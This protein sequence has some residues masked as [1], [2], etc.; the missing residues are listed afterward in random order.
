M[1]EAAEKCFTSRNYSSVELVDLLATRPS[2]VPFSKRVQSL[3][4]RKD[5]EHKAIAASSLTSRN[6]SL[7]LTVDEEKELATEVLLL[8][9]RFTEL[10]WQSTLFSQAALTVIQ[11]IYLFRNRRIFFD[12]AGSMYEDERKEALHLFTSRRENTSLPL[13]K[14]FQHLI[15]ARVWNR[16]TSGIDKKEVFSDEFEDLEKV[17][18]RLNTV[19]N[20]YMLL[21]TGLVKKITSQLNTIYGES[22]T[23]QDAQQVGCFGVARAAYR[24]HQSSGVRFSTYAAHWIK[25]EIQRQSLAGRLI[26]ISSNTVEQYATASKAKD[27]KMLMRYGEIISNSTCVGHSTEDTTRIV[28]LSYFSQQNDPGPERSTE[29]KE[30]KKLVNHLV[31]THLSKKEADVIQ[32]RFALFPYHG[33]PQSIVDIA[34]QYG[35]TRSSVYQ[36][37]D[38]A[39][40]RLQKAFRNAHNVSPRC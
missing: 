8:R 20:I 18:Q 35:V 38:K 22:L 15:I 3:Q 13:A 30:L 24:Y 27:K 12:P 2:Q 10:V 11:N 7:Q 4:L 31:Q 26:R 17:V 25:K 28:E 37:E 33:V 9:H 36:L 16:I 19:R 6:H 21:C 32:R 23:P 1:I 40:K 39:L 14:T 29:I 5:L 34:T